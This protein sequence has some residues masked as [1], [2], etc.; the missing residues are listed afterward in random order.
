MSPDFLRV[1]AIIR[2]ADVGVPVVA[3]LGFSWLAV[4]LRSPAARVEFH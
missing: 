2:I 1:I 4:K 3:C